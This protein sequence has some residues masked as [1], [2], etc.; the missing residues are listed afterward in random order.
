MKKLLQR[1]PCRPR[2][3]RLVK[4]CVC[5]FCLISASFQDII[6]IANG[7]GQP[8][9]IIVDGQD[10][11]GALND[12][13]FITA[14]TLVGVGKLTASSQVNEVIGFTNER[15][16]KHLSTP[17]TAANE[18]FNLEFKPL[19][20]IPVTVW[21]VKG[22]FATQRNHAIEACI[23][24]SSICARS[25]WESMWRRLTSG[26]QRLT[27]RHRITMHFQMGMPAIRCGS[28][29]ATILAS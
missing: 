8:V 17:W 7:S 4:V 5:L 21:I 10:E 22:P 2:S 27:Q 15:P 24:T 9:G 20:R 11:A 23:Q 13:A 14:T 25:G 26:T 3:F 29:S 19:I 1:R 28:L 16:P 18:T 6:T 12:R